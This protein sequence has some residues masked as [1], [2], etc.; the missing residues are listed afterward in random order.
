MKKIILMVVVLLSGLITNVSA[1][2]DGVKVGIKAGYSATSWQGESVKSFNELLEFSNGNVETKWRHGFHAGMFLSIPLGSGFEFEPGVQYSQKGMVLEGRVPGGVGEF[3]NAKVTLTNKAEYIDIPLLA[4]VYVGEGFN[5]FAGPQVSFLLSNNV[6]VNAG[7]LGF[8]AYNNDF[9]WKTA[10]RSVDVGL[11]AGLGY[12][13]QNGLS[14]SGGYDMGL[15]TI[16]D[17]ADY[18]SYNHGFKA[19]VGFRF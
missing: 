17:K 9:E 14:L 3:L 10:Q 5:L 11:S 15:T 7:A 12:Q 4:K 18:K 6:N 16:D 2:N 13:F 19:S 8:S 1:Q